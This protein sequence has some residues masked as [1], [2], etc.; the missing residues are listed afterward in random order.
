LF[1]AIRAP[2]IYSSHDRD[3]GL[4]SPRGTQEDADAAMTRGVAG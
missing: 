1:R 4:S 2:R 3:A